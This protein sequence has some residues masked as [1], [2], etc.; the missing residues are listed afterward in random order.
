MKTFDAVTFW[1]LLCIGAFLG[2]CLSQMFGIVL[3]GSV[4]AL[5]GIGCFAVVAFR[6]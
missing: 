6:S 5:V 3:A 4:T 1:A 2:I